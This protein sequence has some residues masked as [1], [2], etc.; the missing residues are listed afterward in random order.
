MKHRLLFLFCC[1]IAL[2]TNAQNYS[3]KGTDFWITYPAHIDGTTSIMGIYI[4][5]T[6]N[7]SGIITVNG[8]NVPFTVTAN[9]VTEKF[10]GSTAAAD[11]SNSYVYLSQS[12]GIKTGSAIHVVSNDN[13]VVVYAHIIH[14]AR[15]GATLVLPSN[16]WGNQY[17]VP[18]YKSVG[19]GTGQGYGTITVVAS[20]ANTTVQIT[21]TANTVSGKPAGTPFTITLANPGDVYQVEFTQGADISGTVVKSISNSG[22]CLKIAVF[23][24]TTWSSFGC[25]SANSGDNLFQQLFPTGAWGKNFVTTPAKTRTSDI[26]RVFVNDPTTVVTKTENGVT[27]TLSGLQN[28]SFYEYSTGNATYIQANN[29]ISVVQYFTTMACQ[30]GATIGDPEMVVINP[31]EQTINNITVF[32]AHQ[33]WINSRFSGQSNI[34]NCYLNI[35]IRSNAT[36]S[37]K[38]N[39]ITQSG[40]VA[41]PGTSYSY[42]QA[43]VTSI[44]LSNPVQNLTADSNFIAIAYGFGNVESYGYNAGTNVKDFTQIATFQNKYVT[45]DSPIACVNTPFKFSLH[46]NAEKVF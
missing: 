23:S 2:L 22:T 43:D 14:S 45:L 3:N 27:T 40:F 34:T 12:D 10:I 33:N 32:S 4:T 26:I 30:G 41:I 11:A 39:G 18:S 16:V 44:T 42:L 37:F 6:T 25:P 28:N 46:G 31:I 24:S 1:L 19:T 8:I 5:A 21:P 13:P 29:S 9:T 15:S 7:A 17:V 35:V 38:I 20:T 36:S